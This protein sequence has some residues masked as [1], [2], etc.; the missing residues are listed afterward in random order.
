MYDVG[1]GT[2]PMMGK[3]CGDSIPPNLVSSSNKILIHFHSDH[4]DTEAGFQMEYQPRGKRNQPIQNNTKYHRDRYRILGTLFIRPSFA[5][6]P[7]D[8]YMVSISHN[9]FCFGTF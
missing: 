4:A 8:T 6:L 3:Y 5:Y 2:S 7:V 9:I 1:L